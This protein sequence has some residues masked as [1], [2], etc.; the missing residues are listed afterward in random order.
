LSG[1]FFLLSLMKT[2][3]GLGLLRGFAEFLPGIFKQR[4]WYEDHRSFAHGR[5]P[6]RHCWG[7]GGGHRPALPAKAEF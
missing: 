5:R 2:A 6:R 3:R 4:G 7:I 1:T